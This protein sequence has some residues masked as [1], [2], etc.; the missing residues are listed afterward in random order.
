MLRYRGSQRE[1]CLGWWVTDHQRGERFALN[2][3]EKIMLD[4]LSE[5]MD[6]AIA[7]A[8]VPLLRSNK[9]WTPHRI[10]AAK[11]RLLTA[12]SD[13]R[14]GDSIEWNFLRAMTAED[15]RIWVRRIIRDS[16]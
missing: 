8:R 9:F 5:S 13:N 15:W 14:H 7:E 10:D 2:D 4:M 16:N 6:A 3:D 1:H 11:D 12:I